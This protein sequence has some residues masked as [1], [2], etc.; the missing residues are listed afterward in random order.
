MLLSLSVAN[1][2]GTEESATRAVRKQWL[3]VA[4][5]SLA[6]VAALAYYAATR[7][8]DGDEGFY[9][10]ATRLVWQ[11]K[12]PY[13]DFFYQQAPLLPYLYSW[14]WAIH[15]RSLIAMR[16]ISALCGSVAV[17]LWGVSLVS[18]KRLP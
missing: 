14:M 8:I 17:L 16:L 12:V 18:L 11:G 2:R 4:I 9:T 10:T 5:I 6:Y 7:P 13:R 1:S 3:L 15:P